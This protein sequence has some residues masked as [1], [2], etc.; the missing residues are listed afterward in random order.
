M[1]NFY[2]N[3]TGAPVLVWEDENGVIQTRRPVEVS[4]EVMLAA[5]E[6][7]G[8]MWAEFNDDGSVAR[9]DDRTRFL[10]NKK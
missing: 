8:S 3:G 10:S 6:R 2:D 9:C 4:R 1:T 5:R 7:P